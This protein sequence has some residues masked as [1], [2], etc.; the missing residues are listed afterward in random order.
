MSE[1][2]NSDEEAE[3]E[4]LNVFYYFSL[5][6]MLCHKVGPFFSFINKR[7]TRAI[8][9]IMRA[10]LHGAWPFWKHVPKDVRQAWWRT[11]TV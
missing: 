10:Y 1:P 7:M 3:E 4:G 9:P 2:L 5:F 6:Y 11:W 8:L